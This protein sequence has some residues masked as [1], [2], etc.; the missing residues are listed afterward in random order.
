MIIR[1]LY[2]YFNQKF[3][4]L[5]LNAILLAG[6]NLHQEMIYLNEDIEQPG[7]VLPE[8]ITQLKG[9]DAQQSNLD[10]EVVDIKKYN[11]LK[12]SKKRIR[13]G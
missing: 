3:Y 7:F 4:M 2:V 1:L 6:K 9:Q 11:V 5:N 8:N 12:S 10:F 13:N